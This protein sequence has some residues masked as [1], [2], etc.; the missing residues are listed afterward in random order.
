MRIAG[1]PRIA[2]VG[3]VFFLFHKAPK[4]AS[5]YGAEIDKS[6]DAEQLITESVCYKFIGEF[7]FLHGG[8]PP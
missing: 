2:I 6:L 3:E 5:F 7:K 1:D 4:F 8:I